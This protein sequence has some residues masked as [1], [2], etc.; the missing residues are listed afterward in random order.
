VTTHHVGT[1][2]ARPAEVVYHY[3]RDYRALPDWAAGL[4]AGIRQADGVWFSE[5]PMG[6]VTVA[7]APDNP[8]GICDHDVTL[9]D[10]TVATNPLRVIADGDR[11]QVVFTVRTRS[12]DSAADDVRMVQADLDR[13]K[14]TLEG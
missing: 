13:L 5:S 8:W 3:I 7:F 2:I 14:A 9:P 6:R 1:E 4:S 11:C 12:D 10:G